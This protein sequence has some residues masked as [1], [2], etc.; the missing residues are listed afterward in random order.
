MDIGDRVEI[1]RGGKWRS[2]VVVDGEIEDERGP[3]TDVLL[4]EPDENGSRNVW[5][6]H[7]PSR[8][9]RLTND[10]EK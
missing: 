7:V 6:P 5:V 10:E 3:V 8:I 1:W 9:R 2:G 4:D